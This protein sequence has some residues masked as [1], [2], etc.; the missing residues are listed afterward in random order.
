M[1]KKLFAYQSIDSAG[2]STPELLV[3]V[4]DGTVRKMRQAIEAYENKDHETGFEA[5]EKAKTVMVHLYTSL[6]NDKGGDIATKLGKIYAFVIERIN[7]VEATKDTKTIKECIGIL[8]NIRSAWAELAR[9]V[10]EKKPAD[11]K[12]SSPDKPAKRLSVSI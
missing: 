2:K 11:E 6:D 7:Y 4:Y 5:L 10:K 1:N 8:E 3:Q 12:T 9:Q